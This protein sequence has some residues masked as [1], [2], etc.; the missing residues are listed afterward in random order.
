MGI[1][2][3]TSLLGKAKPR[4]ITPTMRAL[5]AIEDHRLSE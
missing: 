4:G 3:W 1:Q 5:V 2:I